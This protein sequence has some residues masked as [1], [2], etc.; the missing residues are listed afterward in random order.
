S[1]RPPSSRPSPRH[2]FVPGFGLRPVVQER[3]PVFGLGFDAHHHSI[4]NRNRF[5]GRFL[6]GRF[7]G[8]R[9]H[10]GGFVGFPFFSTG[11]VG[12]SSVVVQQVPVQVP[13]PIIIQVAPQSAAEAP[14]VSGAGPGLPANWKEKL[15]VARPSFPPL[16]AP[17]PQ[18]TLLVLKDN[19]IFA[20][21]DY[22]LEDGRVFYVTSTGKQDSVALETLDWDLTTQLNAER[23]VGFVLRSPR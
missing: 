23:S 13:V 7:G 22:W 3:F 17:L 19:T 10:R 5:Q 18:L 8:R 2:I 15:R 20:V 12:T 4:L 6:R 1:V 9:F 14:R 11:F 16:Q 21:I